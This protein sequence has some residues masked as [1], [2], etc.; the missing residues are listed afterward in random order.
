MKVQ[1][2]RSSFP[3]GMQYTTERIPGS[4]GLSSILFNPMAYRSIQPE[5]CIRTSRKLTSLL[6]FRLY[7][8]S[9]TRALR[10]DSCTFFWS[11]FFLNKFDGRRAASTQNYRNLT[12]CLARI[13]CFFLVPPGRGFGL[14]GIH[15]QCTP[16]T[17]P[18]EVPTNGVEPPKRRAMKRRA[19]MEVVVVA[20]LV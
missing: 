2:T 13:I 17:L 6:F 11:E 18:R 3:C 20:L 16:N 8:V 14:S 4:R 10:Q 5:T 7:C 1:C 19:P 15:A 12:Y 9:R